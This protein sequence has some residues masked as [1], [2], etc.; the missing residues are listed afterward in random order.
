[1][2]PNAR[3]IVGTMT[4]ADAIRIRFPN[5][6]D[7]QAVY[8]SQARVYGISVEPQDVEAW[9]RRVHLDDILIAEDVS[10]PQRPFLVGTS[11]TYRMR[12]TVPGGASLRAAG[13][14]MIT[15]APTHERTGIWQ[16]LSAQG[17]GIL[18]ER[19]YPILCGLPTHPRIYDGL[20]GGVASYAR[21]YCINRR[22]AK[23]RTTPDRHRAREVNASQAASHLP[24]IYDR[25]RAMTNGALSRDGA[26]WA[27]YLEDRS[28]ERDSGSAL[29]FVIHPDGFLTY[30]VMGEQRRAFRPPLGSV[31]VDDFCPITDEAHTELLHALLRL[32]VFHS[33]EVELPVDDPLPLK[34]IDPRAVQ[35]TA[36]SDFLWL[37]I[38][39]VPEVLG[40]RAYSADADVAVEVT[41][42]LSVAGGR[43]LLQTRDGVG[44]CRPHDGP[45]DVEIGLADLGTIYLGAHRACELHRAG[46]VTELRPGA[47]QRLDAAF[48]IERA[49]YCGTYF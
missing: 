23:L 35:T 21:T 31:V 45:A 3:S 4:T 40:K 30:R 9:K 6:D 10:D 32:E 13:L 14:A 22:V 15:V 33:I 8:E 37:R 25:W 46:R 27:D 16:Q 38:M 29:N 5:D 49:P 12:L 28:T 34:L 48:A 42:P 11:L 18:M 41:D 26:W 44:T 17:F 43:F 24:A 47:L 36:V 19:G 1:M 2:R 39:N 20:G 7:L